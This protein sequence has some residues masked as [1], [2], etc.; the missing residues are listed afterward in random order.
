[1]CLWV[2]LSFPSFPLPKCVKLLLGFIRW[3]RLL[4]LLHAIA[5]SILKLS[6]VVMF[7]FLIFTSV[8]RCILIELGRIL[9]IYVN[10]YIFYPAGSASVRYYMS[11]LIIHSLIKFLAVK[12][13]VKHF[14]GNWI[15]SLQQLPTQLL[16]MFFLM[17]VCEAWCFLVHLSTS[18]HICLV[19]VIDVVND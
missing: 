18:A 2:S 9:H 7:C 10:M 6:L 16:G 1:M 14:W 4:L 8:I 12:L 15:G 5:C 19:G 17:V 3:K 11:P 13:I